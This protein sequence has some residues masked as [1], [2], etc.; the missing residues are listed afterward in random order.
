[1]A[2]K[3]LTNSQPDPTLTL[4]VW[5][6]LPEVIQGELLKKGGEETEKVFVIFVAIFKKCEV[7]K[8]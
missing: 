1:M 8:R 6:V 7:S 2:P 4:I 5:M 3:Y